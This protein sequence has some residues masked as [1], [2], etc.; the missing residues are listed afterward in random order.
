M[1][2]IN[3]HSVYLHHTCD[4]E[5]KLFNFVDFRKKPNSCMIFLKM[6]GCI[7]KKYR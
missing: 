4:E 7:K 5:P 6:L 2:L 1:W 3:L